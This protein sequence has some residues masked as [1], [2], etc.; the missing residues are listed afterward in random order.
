MRPE[1]ADLAT[2]RR[3]QSEVASIREA[4]E[5]YA[6][7]M[8]IHALA[9]TIAIAIAVIMFAKV[10]R[11][12]T[13][14]GK[15]VATVKSNVFQALD[16]NSIIKSIDVRE[17][18]RVVKGQVLA[19]LDPTFTG[20][21]VQQLVD[22]IASLDAQIARAEGEA[23]GRPPKFTEYGGASDKSY[24]ALQAKLYEQRVAHYQAQ[25]NSFDRKVDQTL[26]T[27]K[28]AEGD[29]SRLK[30]RDVIANQ[31]DDMRRK[32]LEKGAGSLLNKLTSE[33][34]SVEM[35]RQLESA[36]NTAIEARQQLAS[37][38]A[39]R[40]AFIQNWST[41]ISQEIVTA[42]NARDTAE[43]QLG[44]ANKRKALVRITAPEDAVV[45]T[46]T[47]LSAGSVL[48]S[49]DQLIT[50][51]PLSAPVEAD[52]QI[53]PRDVGFLR[54]GDPVSLKVDAFNFSQYG[55]AE[56]TIKWI[57][58]GAFTTNDDT[59]Q[60]TDP[61]YRAHV[62]ID[63]LNFVNVPDNF[64]LIPGMTLTGDIKVGRR[65]LASYFWDTLTQNAGEAMREP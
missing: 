41:Q 42:Q 52:I 36:Q 64:R 56:G 7:R 12:I 3:F 29:E 14:A 20:A 5:P 44:K 65:T 48:R 17:G 60:P 54:A 9:A 4:E 46:V 45:L 47:K 31:V 51:T 40:E 35:R 34:A 24:I 16:D 2:V 15:I 26:A 49:G 25:L 19:T 11:V 8:T 13:S 21:D 22:Q 37:L 33:D 58:E 59:G 50:L 28:K 1:A 63:H 55:T 23:L 61:Y 43:A 10:D 18:D 27:I 38:R 32:L 53:S 30:E 57:S 62:T 39:D 6:V